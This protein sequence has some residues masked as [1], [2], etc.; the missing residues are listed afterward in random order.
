MSLLP[1]SYWV[2]QRPVPSPKAYQSRYESRYR[3]GDQVSP[4]GL[5]ISKSRSLSAFLM[6]KQRMEESVVVAVCLLINGLLSCFEMAFV[7]VPKPQLRKL[8]KDGVKAAGLILGLRANPERT[9]SVIQVGITLVGLI[10][11]AV[12]GAG[13]EEFIAPIFEK[14]YGLS[15]N[16]A[17]ILSIIAIVIPLTF[18]NVVLGE[19]VPKTIALRSPSKVVVYGAKWIVWADRIFSPLVS[20]LERATKLVLW[21][22]PKR[23]QE[24]PVDP[25]ASVEID[26][27]STQTRQ[28]VLNLVSAEGRRVKDLMVS[29]ETVIHVPEAATNEEIAVAVV[30]SGHTRLPVVRNGQVIGLLHTKEFIALMA[31][32][33]VQKDWRGLIRPMSVVSETDAA[34]RVLRMMQEKRSHLAVVLSGSRSPIGIITLVDVL[35]D[36]IGDIYDE[37]DDGRMKKLLTSTKIRPTIP[38]R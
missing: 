18:L 35:E 13:A 21:F 9:L 11:A 3:L 32:V 20:L 38:L 25:S 31:A 19:L 22:L 15:E 2:E 6:Y 29:W 14:T 7:S 1:W 8:Q 28:Y 34:L 24:P 16:T 23:G 37:D 30:K 17:E 33:D 5:L 26:H 12:G 10:S 4:P 27:L 36:V